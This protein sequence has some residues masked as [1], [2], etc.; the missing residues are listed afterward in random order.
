MHHIQRA[1]QKSTYQPPK[2]E[3]FPC[4]RLPK[5]TNSATEMQE[6]RK[7]C[8]FVYSHFS[9]A[10]KTPCIELKEDQQNTH[11]ELYQTENTSILAK[12]MENG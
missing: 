6:F 12:D 1:H 11:C 2:Q 10:L 8:R 5:I 7:L 4:H 9:S 3:E